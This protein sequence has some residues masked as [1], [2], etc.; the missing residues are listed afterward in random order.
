MLILNFLVYPPAISITHVTS[1]PPRSSIPLSIDLDLDRD[2]T[3]LRLQHNQ[4]VV[5]SKVINGSVDQ[6]R[7]RDNLQRNQRRHEVDFAVRQARKEQS[8][9][10]HPDHNFTRL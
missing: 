5:V 3:L 2:R 7:P 6:L 8:Q 4:V 10:K 1:I 9:Q